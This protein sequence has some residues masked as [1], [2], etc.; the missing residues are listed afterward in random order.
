[1][2]EGSSPVPGWWGGQAL[3][4]G[5]ASDVVSNVGMRKMLNT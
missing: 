1:M 3:L 5:P 4:Y 2:G